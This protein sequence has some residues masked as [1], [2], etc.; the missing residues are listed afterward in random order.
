[1]KL[2]AVT[3]FL[4]LFTLSFAET[5]QQQKQQEGA[6]IFMYHRFAENRYP[7]T[8]IKKEQFAFELEYLKK[9][10][11]NVWPLS[12]IVRYIKEKKPL[13]PKT[14][15]LTMDDA[16]KSVYTVAYPMLKKMGFPFTVF[17]NTTPIDH[18]SRAFMSW[19]DMREMQRHGAEFANHTLTHPYLLKY[20]K[21]DDASFKKEMR[22]QLERAQRRLHEELGAKCN[23][24]PRMFAYPFG[25]YTHKIEKEV[26]ALG[27]VALTQVPGV[28]THETSLSEIPRFPMAVRFATKK[29]FVLKLN[30]R[31]LPL[32]SYPQ[33]DHLVTPQN[34]P[35]KLHLK[36]KRSVG[37]LNCF[38]SSG[39]K[40]HIKKTGKNEVEIFS[41]KPLKPPREHYTCTALAP[42][43]RW[44]W[45]SFFYVFPR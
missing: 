37:I 39:E 41:T 13:P 45:Y 18:R 44:Y 36:L 7:S 25:E 28:L 20:L 30:T 16:Y 26:K 43:G 19:D 9:H 22:K 27:Y 3:L 4:F 33:D 31:A 1:M 17:V 23:E 14:V 12:K 6:V 15:A 2:R 32:A 24:N 38:V 34:N 40:I 42:D 35:P 5:V 11:Y 29:G 10:H 21:L 8:S